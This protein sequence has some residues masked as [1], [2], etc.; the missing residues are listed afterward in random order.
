MYKITFGEL[1]ECFFPFVEGM[2]ACLVRSTFDAHLK[3]PLLVDGE[4]S[5]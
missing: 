4:S 2:R 5:P 3:L 1:S